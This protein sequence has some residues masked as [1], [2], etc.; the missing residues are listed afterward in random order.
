M[1]NMVATTAVLYG[2][3]YPAAAYVLFRLVR[4]ETARPYPMNR[5]K[6]PL[7]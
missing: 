7:T 5:K 4:C 2:A 1:S 6:E 3:V